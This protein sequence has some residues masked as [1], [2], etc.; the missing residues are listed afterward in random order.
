M[1]K[2]LE[3]AVMFIMLGFILLFLL[4]V[5][6]IGMTLLLAGILLYTLIRRR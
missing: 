4:K 6:V 2:K 1:N 5:V 3:Y